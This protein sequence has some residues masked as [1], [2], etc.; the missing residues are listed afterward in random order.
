MFKWLTNMFT[1][2]RCLCGDVATLRYTLP[3]CDQCYGE[4]G[5]DGKTEDVCQACYDSLVKLDD[6]EDREEDWVD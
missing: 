3:I 2:K 5:Y 4:C 1:K 6:V